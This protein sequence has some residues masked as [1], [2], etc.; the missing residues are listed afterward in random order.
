MNLSIEKTD[1]NINGK[2]ILNNIILKDHM[3]NDLLKINKVLMS[4]FEYNNIFKGQYS[5]DDISL[6]GLSLDIRKY[7]GEEQNNLKI[8]IEKLLSNTDSLNNQKLIKSDKIRIDNMIVKVFEGYENNFLIYDLKNLDFNDFKIDEFKLTSSIKNLKLIFNDKKINNLSADFLLSKNNLQLNNFKT[9]YGQSSLSGELDVNLEKF[10]FNNINSSLKLNGEISNSLIKGNDIPEI[11]RILKNKIEF[12]IKSKFKGDLNKV[13]FNNKITDLENNFSLESKLNLFDLLSDTKKPSFLI[14]IDNFKINKFFLN[15]YLNDSIKIKFLNA[16]DQIDSIQ[17]YGDIAYNNKTYSIKIKSNSNLGSFNSDLEFNYTKNGRLKFLSKIF[18]YDFQLNE[19]INNYEISLIDGVTTFKGFI[20]NKN[21]LD[22]FWDID[23]KK[24]FLKSIKFRNLT[25]SGKY[26]S[27]NLD[28][29]ISSN[30]NDFIFS[31]KITSDLK[32]IKNLNY[33][34]NIKKLSLSA[35]NL[36]SKEDDVFFKGKLSSS[37]TNHYSDNNFSK[38]FHVKSPKISSKK[39]DNLFKD[40]T[41]EFNQNKN[42]KKLMIDKSDLFNFELNGNFLFTDINKLFFNS[43]AKIYPFFKP[44]M[45]NKDQYINFN[46]ELKSKLVNSLYPNFSIP[47]NSFIKGLIGEKDIKSF[48][49][50]NLPLL[51]FGDYKLENISFKGYPYKKNNNSNLFASKFFYDGNVISDLSLISYVNKDKLDFQFKANNINSTN[52]F[53]STN[54]SFLDNEN[55]SI[56]EFKPSKI[57]FKNKYWTNSN[58]FKISYNKT[59]KNYKIDKINL[60]SGDQKINFFGSYKSFDNM[61]I[62]LKLEKVLLE[63]ILPK[64]IRIET[65]GEVNLDF[66]VNRNNGLDRS[67]GDLIINKLVIN[68]YEYGDFELNF[69]SMPENKKYILNSFVKKDDFNNMMA[70]GDLLFS[71]EKISSDIKIE[72]SDF[73]LSFLSKIGVNKIEKI[74]GDISGNVNLVGDIYNPELHG[75]LKL[76]NSSLYIPYTNTEYKFKDLSTVSLSGQQFD[77]EKIVFNDLDYKTEALLSG[78]ISHKNFNNWN[79]DLNVNSSNILLINKKFERKAIFYGKSFL[80]GKIQLLGPTKNLKINVI[81]STAEGTS[82]T[83]PWSESKGLAD[84]S[85]IDFL[86]KDIKSLEQNSDKIPF[87]Q[88]PIR[89]LEMRFEIDVNKNAELEIVVDQN[90]G[91]TLKGRGSGDI[92]MET[93][94]DG[95]FNIWGNLITNEGVYNFKNLGLIEKKFKL[96]SGGNIE[97]DGD[98]L[99][100]KMNLEAVY[101]VLGG[102][103]PAILLDN[104]NFNKKIPTNV[105]I[106][107]QGNLLRPDDPDFQITF[108]N[109]SG[110]V[111]SE[112]NY[113]L[114]DNQRRQLQAIS[115]LSQGV[116]ISEVSISPQG[117]AN[118]LYEKASEV[119]SS[120]IGDN[121][122]KLNVGLN[123]LKGYDNPSLDVRTEDRIGVTLTTQISDK[124]LINGK[125]GVPVDGI[126]ETLIVG[127]FQIDFILNEEGSLKAKVFNKENEFRYIGD[128]L[129]YTQGVG[130]SYDVDFDN[131][132]TLINK[133]INNPNSNSLERKS[134]S[135]NEIDIEYN[136][137]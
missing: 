34:L 59:Y 12:K 36:A 87:D 130:I 47:N 112:L 9:S 117:I 101:T 31:G 60:S 23:L 61:D 113:R 79:L 26:E 135:N 103:N 124:I 77:F 32:S 76:K 132:K 57:N 90:S 64:N 70:Y 48:I 92:L 35:L 42:L 128:E 125:I 111:V 4:I 118:N 84:I 88:S 19:I 51:Q 97:W 38:E 137:K 18:F 85:F 119:F 131:F 110:T 127:D 80:D 68:K 123:Y 75:K 27:E 96:S 89:G 81:G 78:K 63:N 7:S 94:T 43:I 62:N 15:E 122:G 49:E 93:N 105:S 121:Q 106:K 45:I 52:D 3:D 16:I 73:S 2:I 54:F 98:P 10:D 109:T 114:S 53:I 58:S 33:D 39:E 71:D 40:F 129:G 65:K 120:L 116:F 100:A 50:I 102:A 41:I 99:E 14:N 107:L 55:E 29:S 22:I 30:S 37:I 8:V 72:L 56:V 91:S 46:L 69:N 24:I 82:L 28:F 20:D 108:P 11:Q 134:E 17:S 6:S 115:L 44:Y 5:F 67:K 13:T 25:S 133:I 126:E 95:K 136:Y 21:K 1:F 74:K 104:P 83:I 66:Y 86:N